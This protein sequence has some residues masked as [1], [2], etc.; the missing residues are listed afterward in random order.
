MTTDDSISVTFSKM[1]ELSSELEAVL[2][3]LNEKLEDLYGRTERVVLTWEGEARDMFV[4]T[5]DK[6][7]RSMQDMEGAQRWLHEVVVSGHVNYTAAHKA[8]LR[9]WGAA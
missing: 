3:D 8:V 5:L 4:E 7:D 1:H 6:W 9:G 2:K